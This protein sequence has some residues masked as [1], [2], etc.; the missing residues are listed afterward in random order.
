[1]AGRRSTGRTIQVQTVHEEG[2]S[3]MDLTIDACEP[4]RRLALSSVHDWHLDMALAE[5]GGRV[6]RSDAI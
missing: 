4:P 5:S 3:W 2:K 1:M 6:M